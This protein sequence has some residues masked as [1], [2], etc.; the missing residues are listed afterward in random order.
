MIKV[1]SPMP[2]GLTRPIAA[3]PNLRWPALLALLASRPVCFALFQGVI[4]VGLWIPGARAPWRESAG[5]WLVAA[6]PA[7]L[8]TLGLLSGM[9]RREGS[10]LARLYRLDRQQV[11]PDL[12]ALAALTL[13]F[14]PAGYFP[15]VLLGQWLFTDPAMPHELL[16][17]ALPRW[18]AVL[19]ATA[20]PISIALAELPWYGGFLLPRLE[21]RTGSRWAAIGLAGLGLAAQHVTLPLVLDWRFVVWRLLMFLPFA[22][23]VIGVLR[24]R[25]RL[26]P[27]LMVV[28]G[29]MDLQLGLM[30]LAAAR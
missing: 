27:Y 12:L 13:V 17:R 10:S 29:L 5:W 1:S 9:L 30:V 16:F 25:P 3:A 23:L 18:A 20:F 26:L 15:S 11:V 14:A 6:A 8:V 2:R 24:W 22:L 28:H 19:S 7:N 4:A 21:A